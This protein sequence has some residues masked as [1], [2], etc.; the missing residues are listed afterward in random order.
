MVLYID[1]YHAAPYITWSLISWDYLITLN[2]E[3]TLFWF[4]GRSWIKF[5]FFA[6]R[7][8]GLL[9]RIWDIIWEHLENADELFSFRLCRRYTTVGAYDAC[10]VGTESSSV[11]YVTMQLLVIESILVLRIW[12][13]M[14]KRRW[15]L[16]TFFSLLVCSTTTSIVLNLHFFFDS[17]TLPYTIPTLIFEAII[18]VS[19]AYHGIKQSGGLR[20]LLLRD[21]SPFRY[22]PTPILRLVFQGSVLYFTAVLCSLPLMAIVDPRFGITIMSVTINHMLLRLRKQGLSDTVGP[23]SQ[24]ELTTLR[25]TA[26]RAMSLEAGENVMS[27]GPF[28]QGR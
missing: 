16:W 6:N 24:V 28:R 13:I 21:T 11:L 12:A 20:S 18:F 25:A 4:S 10:A 26:N 17:A 14:G 5:L 19:A 2:D 7:Y 3:I 15:I 22:G 8:M 9:L 23:P 1:I 27:I